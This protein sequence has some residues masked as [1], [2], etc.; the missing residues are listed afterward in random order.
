M[1]IYSL[2]CW[3]GSVFDPLTRAVSFTQPFTGLH[4]CVSKIPFLSQFSLDFELL[5]LILGCTYI[6]RITKVL[7]CISSPPK[8][9]CS[10]PDVAG[11]TSTDKSSELE[12]LGIILD[13][14]FPITSRLSTLP[15]FF[16]L[17]DFLPNPPTTTFYQAL[18]V[19]LLE[20]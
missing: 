9:V 18:P 7:K 2:K 8:P 16:C 15:G 19:F 10:F 20:H 12:T 1:L 4:M 14:F 6:P 11:D 5:C 13:S 17:L 3:S